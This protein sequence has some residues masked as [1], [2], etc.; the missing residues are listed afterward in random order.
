MTPAP[1]PLPQGASDRAISAVMVSYHTGAVLWE[2][3]AAALAEPMIAELWLIDNGNPPDVAARLKALSQQDTRLHPVSGHG[4]IGF[5]QACNLACNLG[6]AQAS[7]DLI[8]LLNPDLVLQPGAAQALCAALASAKSPAVIGGRV[9]GADGRE[10][11]GSRRDRLGPWNA[12]VSAFG[13][14]RLERHSP[15]FR[16]PHRERD[17]L[18]DGPI[19]VGAVSGALMLL[20]REDYAAL[21]G[22]DRAYFL[23]VED[24]DLCVRAAKAGGDVLFQPLAVGVH[25]GASSNASSL[26]IERHKA[27]GFARYFARH[28]RSPAERLGGAVASA[29]LGAAFVA[30]GIIRDWRKR[31]L[32][33][34]APAAS[35]SSTRH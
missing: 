4:N 20:R 8:L 25:V 15:L 18:P 9:M 5:G 34:N 32:R 6:A 28:A 26:F 13:L 29:L 21:S 19:P 22:F 33:A 17:P 11:R 27:R 24:L 14:G 23:H 1:A 12:L 16:D 10:Q 7:A 3:L 35:S 31:G 2:S 30:R